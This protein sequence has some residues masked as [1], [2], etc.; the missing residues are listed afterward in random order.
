[1]DKSKSAFGVLCEMYRVRFRLSM[2][3]MAKEIEK[4]SYKLGRKR[5]S[6]KQP[7]ISQFE[8]RAGDDTISQ[9]QHRD[10]PLEYVEVCS[11]L[12]ELSS[13]DKFDFFVSALQSSEKIDFKKQAI[14]GYIEK[15][16]LDII[17]AL[18]L[19]G[20][21][22]GPIVETH[23]KNRK[24]P[25]KNYYYPDKPHESLL[26]QAWDDFIKG[27]HRLVDEVKKNDFTYMGLECKE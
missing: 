19:S 8:R 16:I 24:N 21:K 12:F 4:L 22:L 18:I 25:N 14:E 7:L 20:S 1:M 27:A 17:V 13:T 15:E 11:R 9:N 23:I 6:K 5:E 3:E 26:V 10:P 2:E